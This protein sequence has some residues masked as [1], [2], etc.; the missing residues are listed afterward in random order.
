MDFGPR[1]AHPGT[2]RRRGMQRTS[3]LRAWAAAGCFAVLP[4][5]LNGQAA[6]GSSTLPDVPAAAVGS[7]SLTYVPGSSVKL[8]QVIG[9]CDWQVE[10]QK[11]TCQPTTS[12]TV[13]RFN[14]LGNGQGGSFEDNE[15]MI[16][17]FGDT[18]S[19]DVN[20]VNYH[21]AD[22]IAWSTST[23]PEA[24]LLLNFFTNSDGSPLFVKPPGIAMG[25]DA[26][27][28]AG[29]SLNGQIYLVCNIGSDTSL[30]DPQSIDTSVLV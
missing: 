16:F 21:G 12:Q 1:R 6:G 14:I 29:I 5:M 4:A 18:I 13:T 26:I 11:G 10:A 9:D 2:Q 22:P 20:L 7:V 8:E 30:A 24:G 28:N 19:K 25:P 3:L 23:N 15:K 27:P 17:L